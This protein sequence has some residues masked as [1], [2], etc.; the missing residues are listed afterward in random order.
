MGKPSQQDDDI[1]EGLRSTTQVNYSASKKHDDVPAVKAKKEVA[2]PAPSPVSAEEKAKRNED[3]VRILQKELLDARERLKLGNPSAAGDI[4]ALEKELARATGEIPPASDSSAAP[5]DQ[6]VVDP[7]VA[8]SLSSA[9]TVSYGTTSAPP[10]KPL[11]SDRTKTELG[12]GATIGAVVGSRQRKAEAAQAEAMQEKLS[13]LP[14]EMRPVNPAALQRYINSQ[15]SVSIPLEKLKELTGVDIRTMK[16]VQEARRIIEGR[17]A[18]REP[19]VKD[20]DGRRTT[21]SYRAT[22]AQQP[23]DISMFAAEPP[24]IATRIGNAIASGTKSAA[25]NALKYISPIAGGAVALPQLAG[26]AT[27]YFKNKTVDPTQ[28]TSGLGGLAMMSR[29]APIGTVGALAQIPYAIK[30]RDELARAMTMTDVNPT[31]FPAGTAGADEPL[32]PRQ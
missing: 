23:I 31:A 21:V 2:A 25:T 28:V 3:A 20:V 11:I 26:A 29:S 13:S 5:S 8:P 14:P 32:V 18:S 17:E 15:F 24:S 30:H 19:V 27:D 10:K 6:A 1:P 9:S 7:D 12:L 16:E 4:R 22:P